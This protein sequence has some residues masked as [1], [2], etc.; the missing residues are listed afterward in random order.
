[1]QSVSVTHTDLISTAVRSAHTHAVVIEHHT[2]SIFQLHQSFFIVKSK[3]SLSS[4]SDE[5]FDSDNVSEFNV[6]VFYVMRDTELHSFF[7]SQCQVESTCE[8]EMTFSLNIEQHE[9][10]KI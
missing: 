4:T 9:I 6:T 8:A 10:N 2:T 1:M 3:L 7:S 5:K